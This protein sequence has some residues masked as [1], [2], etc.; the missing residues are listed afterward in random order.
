[1]LGVIFASP[2]G[3]YYIKLTGPEGTVKNY[4]KGFDEWLKAFK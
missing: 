1:M 4:K 3:P 2:K